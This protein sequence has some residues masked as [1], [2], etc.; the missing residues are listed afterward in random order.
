MATTRRRMLLADF[1][2]FIGCWCHAELSAEVA[3]KGVGTGE[4][5][6]LAD[7]LDGDVRLGIHQSDGI[8]QSQLTDIGWQRIGVATLGKGSTNALLRQS[9]T[10]N[11]RLA[12]EVGLQEQLLVLYQVA[13]TQEQLFVGQRSKVGDAESSLDSF[14]FK[15]L[16]S[17]QTTGP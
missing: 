17:Y 4:S 8:V 13:Q 3:G 1:R 16:Q 15:S 10:V 9:C 6:G 5:T 14:L 2:L 7:L 12:P 11:E